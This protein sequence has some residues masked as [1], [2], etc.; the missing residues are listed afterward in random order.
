MAYVGVTPE[1]SRKLWHSHRRYVSTV[2]RGAGRTLRR[3]AAGTSL[4]SIAGLAFD[5]ARTIYSGT[6]RALDFTSV[7]EPVTKRAKTMT[8]Y[9]GSSQRKRVAA[10]AGVKLDNTTKK[11]K[12]LGAHLQTFVD[13]F[14]AMG[15]TLSDTNEGFPGW[16][17]CNYY[18]QTTGQAYFPYYLFDLTCAHLNNA[19]KSDGTG[20]GDYF[21]VPL[22]RLK[23]DNATPY[24]YYFEAMTGRNSSNSANSYHWQVEQTNA[25]LTGVNALPN[26]RVGDKGFVDWCDI[27]LNLF[28]ATKC[29]VRAHVQIIQFNEEDYCPGVPGVRYVNDVPTLETIETDSSSSNVSDKDRF[30]RWQN[31]WNQETDRLIGNPLTKRGLDMKDSPYRVLFSRTFEYEPQSTDDEDITPSNVEFQLKYYVDKVISYV[32][33]PEGARGIVPQEQAD[34]NEWDTHDNGKQSI[35]CHPKGR[36]YLKIAYE[37]P[38]NTWQ[39]TG[40]LVAMHWSGSFDLMVRRKQHSL[41]VG[42]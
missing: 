41:K 5:A 24:G 13:R 31:F 22:L 9:A 3:I 36:V 40:E 8:I 27:R 28:G 6:K 17:P 32:R 16:Y 35:A 29:P 34:A 4:F 1:V 37:T 10:K 2:R 19:T 12:I 26:F 25:N 39:E 33:N 14:Q 18:K 11:L 23:R 15:N 30:Y 7:E 20:E 38:K 42:V 21:G